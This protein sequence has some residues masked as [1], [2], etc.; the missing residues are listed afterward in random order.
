MLKT[1][2]D[3]AK[4]LNIKSYEEVLQ[5]PKY[6]EF[7]TINAC[8]ARCLMCTIDEWDGNPKKVVS[9]ELW[10]KF[11]ENVKPHKEWIEK[12]TLTRDGEPLLDTK[13]AQ[14]IKTLK[15]AG[16]K[17][18]VIVTNAQALSKRKSQE[19][20][21]AGIDEIYFSV[22]GYSKEA[23]EKI[24]VGLS[25]ERVL[26]NILYFIVLR[27]SNFPNT[28][29]RLRMIEQEENMFESESWLSFWKSKVDLEKGDMVYVMPLHSWGN[30]LNTE[31][32][33]KVE[34]MSSFACISPFSSMAIHYDGKV[35]ICGV[36]YG[37]KHLLGD[38]SKSS[39]EYIWQEGFK[40]AR[41]LH[42][43]SKRNDIWLC[44]GCDL[45][46]RNYKY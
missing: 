43:N 45:W 36:D 46:D 28:K 18:V 3:I 11:V 38:F 13:I 40:K 44:R 16:I 34:Y 25:Y 27:D 31:S 26:E 10:R 24:R 19:I 39:I 12:I 35:G 2:E 33:D 5:F 21:E 23:Y 22:D 14:R 6:F 32:I 9:D 1:K 8:N 30:Q 20:L 15:E 7:E 4:R 17:K 37:S 29:I 41:E 42:L